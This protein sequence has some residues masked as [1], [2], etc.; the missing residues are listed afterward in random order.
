MIKIILL[1][2]LAPFIVGFAAFCFSGKKKSVG[3]IL[4]HRISK[5]FPKSLS[6]VSLKQFEKFCKE[7]LKSNKKTVNFSDFSM[8]NPNEISITFDDGHKS[9]YDFAFP[10]LKK[11]N[12]TATVFA[13]SGIITGEK[14]D[15][16]Y[17]TKNMISA[18][19]LR[20]L[21]ENGWEIA[22]H[23][24]HHLDLTLLDDGDLFNELETSKE[25]LENLIEKPV[26]SLSFPYGSSSK[27]VIEA[28]KSCG[29]EKFAVYRR[30]RRN[31]F[32][33]K[34]SEKKNTAYIIPATAVFPFDCKN[35]MKN[36]ISG[37]ISGL[38]KVLA[39][40]IPHFAKGTPVFFWNKSYN[41][42]K[43]LK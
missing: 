32:A 34:D 15:D 42:R 8:Q 5:T 35:D 41:F 4:F 10:I 25:S 22:S 29:Y 30:L 26:K 21:S 9:V 11:Y 24:V 37:E 2:I 13:A 7:V 17:S 14:I 23:G 20:E 16:F 33:E 43:T 12:L 6:E 40:V 28:A 38:T 3:V 31:L 18:E 1:F 39:S 36:K 19:N 27:K